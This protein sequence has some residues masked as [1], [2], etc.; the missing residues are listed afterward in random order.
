MMG[1][2]RPIKVTFTKMREQS[3]RGLIAPQWFHI[4]E[5]EW[6]RAGDQNMGDITMTD[7]E[8]GKERRHQVEDSRDITESRPSRTAQDLDGRESR[9]HG[10]GTVPAF[11]GRREGRT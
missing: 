3:V 1:P 6:C 2:A 8:S 10:A 4:F 5:A 7:I 9:G 11:G